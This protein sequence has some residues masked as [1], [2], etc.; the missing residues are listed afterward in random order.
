MR[1]YNKISNSINCKNYYKKNKEDILRR[2]NLA[3]KQKRRINKNFQ[4]RELVRAHTAYFFNKTKCAKCGSRINLEF[5]HF[6]YRLPVQKEDFTVLCEK[7][8]GELHNYLINY[9]THSS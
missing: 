3:H 5:H 1:K 2:Q 9:P 4:I 7:H 6:V 8:H